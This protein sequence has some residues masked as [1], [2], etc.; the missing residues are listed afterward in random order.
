MGLLSAS[1]WANWSLAALR[2]L[3][4]VAFIQDKLHCGGV[5]CQTILFIFTPRPTEHPCQDPTFVA[6]VLPRP[7][8]GLC[9]RE[10]PLARFALHAGILRPKAVGVKY[11]LT[12][13]LACR[14]VSFD[15]P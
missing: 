1:I 5:F 13:H 2:S 7:T 12:E 9:G 14:T 8:C 4:S 11:H 10:T 15:V 6:A 3:S